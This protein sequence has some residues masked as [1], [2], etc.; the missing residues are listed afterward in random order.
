M[1]TN[2]EKPRWSVVIKEALT[3][4]DL[5]ITKLVELTGINEGTLNKIVHGYTKDPSV[6]RMMA[7]AHA[8]EITLDEL[9]D[10]NYSPTNQTCTD[11]EVA[12]L[13]Y[14]RDLNPTGQESLRKTAAGLTFVGEYKKPNINESVEE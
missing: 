9:V 2:T 5:Q 8:L 4:K 6:R 11:E 13:G 12:L 7:I 14:F 1:R 10:E 3:R